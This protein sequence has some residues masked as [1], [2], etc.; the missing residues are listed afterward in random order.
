MAVP[1]DR[2]YDARL[3]VRPLLSRLVQ[4]KINRA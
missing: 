2:G 1:F 3:K 4:G